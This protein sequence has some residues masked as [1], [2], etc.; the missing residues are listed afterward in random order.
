MALSTSTVP[1]NAPSPLRVRNCG[2]VRMLRYALE[3][4]GPLVVQMLRSCPYTPGVQEVT[5]FWPSR[6]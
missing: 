4:D 1:A 2:G 3:A 6:A 5:P